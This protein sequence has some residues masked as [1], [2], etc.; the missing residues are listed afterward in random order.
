LKS[1]E[2][3]R[4]H[5]TA[6]FLNAQIPNFIG[7]T[8]RRN[9]PDV[10]TKARGM[11][12]MLTVDGLAALQRGMAERPDS[13]PMLGSINVDTLII[14]GEEDTLLSLANAE[15]MRLYIPGAKLQVLPQ[16]GHYAALE[17][18]DGFARVLRQFL[19][20]LQLSA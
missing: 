5:G 10:V 11:M 18:P 4:Q 8:T 19:D 16:T 15:L 3:A 12:D 20:G 6:T 14:A 2:D 9:R 13:V 7:E 1:I 17:N